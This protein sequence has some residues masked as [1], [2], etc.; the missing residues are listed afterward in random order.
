MAFLDNIGVERL[1][2][3]IVLRTQEATDEEVID[4]FLTMD[5]MPVVTDADGNI[6]TDEN[7][8]I[9]LV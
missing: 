8:A 7:D 9:L 5:M 3:H 4:L 6:I 2:Q 1:W